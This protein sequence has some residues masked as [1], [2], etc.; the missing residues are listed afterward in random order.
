MSH[1]FDDVFPIGLGSA[2][3]PF[4]SP[5]T[6]ATDFEDAVNLVLYALDKGINYIDVGKGYSTNKAFSVLKEAFQRTDKKFYVTVK[7]N[8]YDENY[9]AEDYYQEALFVLN[10]MGLEKASH[11]LLWTLMSSEQYHQAVGKNNLYDAALRLKAEGRIQYIGTSVHMQPDEIMEVIDSGLFEFVLVSYHLINFLDMRKVLDRAYER[12][13]DILVMNPLFGGLIAENPAPFLYAK[14]WENET[15]VQAA[16]RVLLSH[17]AVKCV[18][19]G[20]SNRKQLDEYLSTVMDPAFNAQNKAER[21]K[22]VTENASSSKAFC[23]YCRYCADCP[24]NIPI[25][26]IM[27]ARN[28]L[29]LEGKE[30]DLVTVRAFFRYLNE[31]FNV[32]FDTYENPCI[33]CGQCEKKCTQH[34]NIIESVDEIYNIVKKTSYDKSSRRKRFDELINN[35]G[36][37]KVGFWPASA[38]TIKILEIYQKLFGSFPFEVF[39]FDSNADFYG[40]NRFGYIVHSKEDAVNMGVDCILITSFAYGGIIYDQVKDLEQDGINVKQLYREGDVDWWW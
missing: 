21:L 2:R 8:A 31:K 19:A 5:E 18:L 17:P 33:K 36:Y 28:F 7:V 39:L 14:L 4:L 40:K 6:Y 10:E 34:L 11:F 1:A 35:K 3:F 37:Q 32:E 29:A 26:Q 25:P 27:N 20:A 30:T 9:V 22:V 15:I 24:R 38:G 13:V 23:S 16:I 12:D